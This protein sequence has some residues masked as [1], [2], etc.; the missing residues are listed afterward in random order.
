MQNLEDLLPLLMTAVDSQSRVKGPLY[1]LHAY[2]QFA[3]GMSD[4]KHIERARLHL[5]SPSKW[6]QH[7][8]AVLI[9]FLIGEGHNLLEFVRA[10]S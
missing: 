6:T 3:K 7:S 5:G 8:T 10:A 4:P 2:L 9:T 1:L